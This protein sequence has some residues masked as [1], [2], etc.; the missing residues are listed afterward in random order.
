[1]ARR[2]KS[3]RRLD[4]SAKIFPIISN[5][6]FSTIFRLSVVLKENINSRILL[7]AL[8]KTMKKFDTFKVKQKKGLFWYYLEDNEKRVKI[9]KEREYPCK[10]ID[11]VANNKYL[12]KVTYFEK[13]INLEVFHSL[14]DGNTAVNFLKELVYN[15]LDILH[16]LNYEHDTYVNKNNKY[17]DSYLKNYDKNA[18]KPQRQK[19]AYLL[20]GKI[21]PLG[22]VGVTHGFVSV[23]E[24]KKVSKKYSA[25]ITEYITAR[26]MNA[27]YNVNEKKSRFKNNLCICIPVNLKKYFESATLLNFFAC[28]YIDCNALECIKYKS[29]TEVDFDKILYKVKNEFKDKINENA[30]KTRVAQ[31][32]KIGNNSLIRILPLILKKAAIWISYDEIRKYVTTTFSNLGN[33]EV[34]AKYRKY[35]DNF[36]VLLAPEKSEK[37]KCSACSYDDKFSFSFTSVLF[38]NDIEKEF[39]RLLKEDGININFDGNGVYDVIS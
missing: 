33:I 23:N 14:T 19:K 16:N 9:E 3:W 1:M 37:L 20:K 30:L 38:T 29:D 10:Y 4:N 5:K 34:S 25:T 8:N 15:Y 28:A 11:R 31:D 13:K 12:F 7:I 39:F 26:I 21:L 32:V 17:E 35:I 2:S 18:Y 6:Q 24:L 36:L 22:A 27:I